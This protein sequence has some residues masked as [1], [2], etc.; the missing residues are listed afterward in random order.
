MN[1]PFVEYLIARDL[2]SPKVAEQLHSKSR[3]LREPVGMIAVSHGLLFPEQIDRILDRQRESQM[4]FGEI[5]EELGYLDK[6]QVDTL[7]KIQELRAMVN[8]GEALAL[9]EVM[10]FDDTCHYLGNY[11][12]QNQEVIEMIAEQ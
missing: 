12:T 8:I 2:V 6:V 4:R 11:L 3:Y 7:L 9:S 10:P 1:N 5:A